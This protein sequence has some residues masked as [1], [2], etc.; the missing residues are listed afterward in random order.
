M[1]R[2]KGRGNGGEDKKGEERATENWGSRGKKGGGSSEKKEQGRT[3]GGIREGRRLP[4]RGRGLKRSG[5][6]RG[7]KQGVDS[8]FK[9]YCGKKRSRWA[10]MS[11]S[12]KENE[13]RRG[14]E[15]KEQ[16]GREGVKRLDY[17]KD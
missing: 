7:Y 3:F 17:R 10:L 12:E 2:E 14:C 15:G 6:G 16:D 11:M 5:G 13:N 1:T 9:N 8:P 4:L